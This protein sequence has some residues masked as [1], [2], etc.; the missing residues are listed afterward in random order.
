M[1]C[2]RLFSSSAKG[3]GYVALPVLVQQFGVLARVDVH[4]DAV[5]LPIYAKRSVPLNPISL[6]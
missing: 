4:G 6:G 2:R 5:P 3:F 1:E